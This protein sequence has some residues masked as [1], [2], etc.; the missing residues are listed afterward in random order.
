MTGNKFKNIAQN[1]V[2]LGAYGIIFKPFDVE[3]VLNI[4]K[5][6]VE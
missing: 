3:E 1:I 6:I 5:E 4:T 2:A